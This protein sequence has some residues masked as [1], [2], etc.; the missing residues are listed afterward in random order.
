MSAPNVPV[1]SDSNGR[2]TYHF[3]PGMLVYLNSGGPAMTVDEPCGQRQDGFVDV[4]WFDGRDLK[5]DAIHNNCLKT[6]PTACL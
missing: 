5:R 3:A 1:S 6:E 2:V 4:H